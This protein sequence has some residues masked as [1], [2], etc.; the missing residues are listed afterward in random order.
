MSQHIQS[1]PSAYKSVNLDYVSDWISDGD[2]V[3]SPLIQ[4]V[5]V[6]R[7][8]TRRYHNCMN[9]LVGLSGCS[10]NL[11][12]FMIEDMD[13]NNMISTGKYFRSRFVSFMDSVSEGKIRYS[14]STIKRSIGEIVKVGFALSNGRGYI[15]INPMYY[16]KNDDTARMIMIKNYLELESGATEKLLELKK[17]KL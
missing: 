13:E 17:R 15:T 12:E 8:F 2:G 11:L 10:R 4:S 5:L 1:K 7:S 14:D 9:V 3:V 16:T 6:V